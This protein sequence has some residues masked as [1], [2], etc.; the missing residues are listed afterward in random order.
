MQQLSQPRF[1]RFDREDIGRI[2]FFKSEAELALYPYMIVFNNQQREGFD[3]D[4]LFKDLLASEFGKDIL[5]T[6]HDLV[7]EQG[8]DYIEI[9]NDPVEKPTGVMFSRRDDM[10]QGVLQ[11]LLQDDGDV[12]IGLHNAGD[13]VKNFKNLSVEFCTIGSGG[14]KSPNTLKALQDLVLAV[15]KDTDE[16]PL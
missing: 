3:D 7:G 13:N 6:I 16:N 5:Y 15:A 10:G 14:G 2:V 4:I 9:V 12:C 11:V 8:L 1:Y